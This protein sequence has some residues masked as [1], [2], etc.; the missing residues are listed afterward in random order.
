M[1]RTNYHGEDNM[2]IHRVIERYLF[3]TETSHQD[4]TDEVGWNPATTSR[5]LK[6]GSISAGGLAKLL[7]WMLASEGED[8][9]GATA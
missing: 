9:D 8:D 6:S 3:V 4:F 2:R 7:S 5:F 1:Q